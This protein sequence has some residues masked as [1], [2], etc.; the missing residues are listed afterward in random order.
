MLRSCSSGLII[1]RRIGPSN[2][3]SGSAAW[4]DGALR[5]R[6]E[7]QQPPGVGVTSS[8]EQGCEGHDRHQADQYQG[9]MEASG[10]GDADEPGGGDSLLTLTHLHSVSPVVVEGETLASIDGGFV[11]ADGVVFE[12]DRVT[13]VVEQL[14]WCQFHRCFSPTGVDFSRLLLYNAFT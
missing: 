1:A 4:S 12:A 14:S 9:R 8:Q 10:G 13:H 7:A 3:W 5:W 2:Q 11:G 6:F